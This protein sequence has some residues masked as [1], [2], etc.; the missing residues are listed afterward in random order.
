MIT[1]VTGFDHVAITVSDLDRSL[2]FYRDALGLQEVERHRL[3]GEGISAMAGKPGV[4]MDVVRLTTG[5]PAAILVD[6]QQ[7]VQPEGPTSTAEL[8]DVAHTHVCFVVNDIEAACAEL[9]G[10]GVTLVSDPVSFEL[11]SGRL[12]VVFV[13]DPDGAVIEL[14]EYPPA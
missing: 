12:R 1:A 8:G 2:A 10:R 3:E 9:R 5:N 7:Y 13:K 6:L 14:V 4:V 11:E